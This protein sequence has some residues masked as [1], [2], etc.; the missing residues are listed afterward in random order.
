MIG[1]ILA[2]TAFLLAYETK[3]LLI[4][5]AAADEMEEGIQAIV[6]THPAVTMV[7]ELRTL[8]RGPNEVLLT[9]SLDFENELIVGRLEAMISELERSIRDEFPIVKRIFIEA[10]AHRDHLAAGLSEA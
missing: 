1:I 5:E 8:H 10:Q 6:T 3:G 4:G 9:L 7:N 2:A